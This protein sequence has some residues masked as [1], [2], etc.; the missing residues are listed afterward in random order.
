MKRAAVRQA[1]AAGL[2][3]LGALVASSASAQPVVVLPPHI[4]PEL[5]ASTRDAILR[6]LDR[7]LIAEGAEPRSAP[8]N[9]C[10]SGVCGPEVAADLQSDAVQL[11]VWRASA[12]GISGVSV[13]VLRDGLRYSEG[14]SLTGSSDGAIAAAVLAATRGAYGRAGR[15]PGPWLEVSGRPAGASVVVDGVRVGAVPGRYRV[16]GGLHRVAVH[17]DGF[18]SHDATVTVPRNADGLKHIDVELRMHDQGQTEANAPEREAT[19]PSPLNFAVAGAAV[20]LGAVLAI[21]PLRSVVDDGECGREESGRC[22][23]VIE[24]DGGSA[25]Q[26]GAATVFVLGGAAFAVWA[27]LRVQVYSDGAEARVAA[28][29]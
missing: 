26:L 6:A 28:R 14:A 21:G 4:E 2:V 18:V 23:G 19:R 17:A 1:L 12:G 3:C 13:A 10:P 25:V 27:P 16:A 29:F 20:I 8:A 9:G 15:G 22:T 11:T 5:S 24:F 7:A